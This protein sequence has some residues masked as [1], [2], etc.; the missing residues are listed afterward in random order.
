MKR[1]ATTDLT[2]LLAAL[3]PAAPLAHR[4]LW[5]IHLLDWVRGQRDS[6]PG[7]VARFQLFLDAVQARPEL[8][9]RLQAWWA[10]LI[11]TVD[12]QVLD[13]VAIRSR[14]AY[15]YRVHTGFF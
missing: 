13:L 8:Q 3:D 4:H 10:R 5:L 7:A 15:L 12:I 11:D 9:A 2:T 14:I 6:V 1:A